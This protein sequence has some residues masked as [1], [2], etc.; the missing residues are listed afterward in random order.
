MEGSGSNQAEPGSSEQDFRSFVDQLPVGVLRLSRDLQRIFMNRRLT[1]FIGIPAGEVNTESLRASRLSIEVRRR[2]VVAAQSVLNAGRSEEIEFPLESELGPR[3]ISLKLAPEF[4]A[5][6]T[7]THVMG[8][9]FDVTERRRAEENVRLQA[10]TD[11]LTGLYNRRGFLLLAEQERKV[12]HRTRTCAV[13][14]FID[15]DGLKRINDEHGHDA[16]DAVLI[17][18]SELLRVSFR[19]ADIIARL[20]GDEFVVLAR[21][22]KNAHLLH[23]RLQSNLAE[24]NRAV[25]RPYPV[26]ISIGA[27]E[28]DSREPQSL[29]S[30]IARADVRMY[31]DKRKERTPQDPA[32]TEE[33]RARLRTR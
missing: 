20:G 32:T 3:A 15:V 10:I 2:I 7:V 30:Q 8:V 14:F 22:C 23:E 11:D 33:A 9:A 12:L 1:E 27:T 26:S 24:H 18:V 13:L 31:R 29:E 21:D 4:G 28:L 5:D 17:A 19:N 6:G 16:G 25:P